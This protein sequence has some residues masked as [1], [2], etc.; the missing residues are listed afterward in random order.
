MNEREIPRGDDVVGLMTSACVAMGLP[1]PMTFDPEIELNNLMHLPMAEALSRIIHI[2]MR[3]TAAMS[4]STS[5]ALAKRRPDM[6]AA[7]RNRMRDIR[8]RVVALAYVAGEHIDVCHETHVHVIQQPIPGL[9]DDDT[10][11]PAVGPMPDP[12]TVIIPDLFPVDWDEGMVTCPYCG[13]MFPRDYYE[14]THIPCPSPNTD[15]Q[16]PRD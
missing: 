4:V 14:R 16:P 15:G 9:L 13:H 12:D 8:E 3:L 5:M 10:A 1:D 6:A 2:G 11:P 7:I